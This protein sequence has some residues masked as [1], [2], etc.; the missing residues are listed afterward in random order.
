MAG[1][2]EKKRCFDLF[3]INRLSQRFKCP[4]GDLV[5]LIKFLNDFEK[6]KSRQ[7]DGPRVPFAE[8]GF[9]TSKSGG[10]KSFLAFEQLSDLF[11]FHRPGPQSLSTLSPS[12][13]PS[14]RRTTSRKTS[15]AVPSASVDST[16]G[17][18]LVS[19]GAAASTNLRILPGN[20]A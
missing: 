3:E 1:R 5:A 18:A 4:G 19:T 11:S 12:T 6:I 9:E 16:E 7:I 13:S 20:R 2:K 15:I 10:T 17:A 8:R 14:P